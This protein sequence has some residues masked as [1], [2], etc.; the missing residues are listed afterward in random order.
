[1]EE[2]TKLLKH[3][4]GWEDKKKYSWTTVQKL[5]HKAQLQYIIDKNSNVPQGTSAVYYC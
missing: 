1:M 3:L 2:A 5:S 4:D